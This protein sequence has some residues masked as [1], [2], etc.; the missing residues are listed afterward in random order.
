MAL[1]SINPATGKLI[2]RY[3]EHSVR[4][5][6]A[7]L[8]R[9]LEAH[10]RLMTSE[11]GKPLAQARAE[12]EKSALGCDY[13]ARHA[14]ALLAEEHP[15]GSPPKSFVTFQPIGVVLAV[16]PWNFPYWQVFRAAAPALMA[17]NTVLLKHASSV[18]GCALAIESVFSK[19]G[20]PAGAFQTLLIS[21]G[22][23]PSLIAN[24]RVQ[25]VTLT[26]SGTAGRQTAA[27][28]GAALKKCVLE[29]GGSDPYVILADADLDLA[30]EVC[31]STRLI[32]SG[33]SC[34]AAKRFIV[35]EKVRADFER[36][37]TARM[38]ARKVGPP[39]ED[40][41]DVGPLARSDL[42]DELH[43]QVRGSL[44][45]GARLL[46]GGRP[47]PGPGWFY[48]PTILT[49]VRPGMPAYDEEL[50]GPVAA[51][52]PVRDQAAALAVANDSPF[53][54]GAAVFT[55]NRRLGREIAARELEAGLA[56]VNTFVRSDPSLPFGG[57]KQSGF[58]REL[59]SFGIREFVNIKTVMMA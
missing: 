30:A 50:F 29:L 17:G 14:P 45:R 23:V 24:P 4:H 7:L 20:F 6:A 22:R 53:G 26:G 44:R 15:T 19:A 57:V 49:D 3:R 46:L 39:M 56:C 11:M 37:F 33:Q 21:A 28:A 2:R 31:A 10:A 34:I 41:I 13:Y 59:G 55:R 12:V 35:V 42:R 58:G 18:C 8:R 43:S 48:E 1:V 36:R 40:G 25:A 38:A 27:L 9:D 47:L 5:Q 54:L 16:M 52:I 32:N 51:V